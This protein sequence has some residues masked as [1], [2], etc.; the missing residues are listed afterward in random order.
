MSGTSTNRSCAVVGAGAAG[1]AAARRLQ[2]A[3]LA[4][5]LFDK[6]RQPGGRLASRRT[7]HGHFDHGLR[8]LAPQQ[9]HAESPPGAPLQP[10]PVD[11]W[12]I[13]DLRHRV[14]PSREVFV[15]VPS[16]NEIARH[17]ST[18]LNLRQ[19]RVESIKRSSGRWQVDLVDEASPQTFD[20]VV[21][22]V[23]QPQLQP[24][25]PDL[26]L[27]ADLDTIA[28]NPCWTLLWVPTSEMPL[29]LPSG[30]PMRHPSIDWLAREDSKP[31][32]V[33]PA[34]YVAH[35]T[36]PWSLEMLEQPADTVADMLKKDAA[37]LLGISAG[38]H[39]AVSHRWRFAHVRQALGR[40]Q[41]RLAAGLHYASDGCLGDGVEH[42]IASGCAAANALLRDED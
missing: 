14:T 33:G 41:R 22:T 24:L 38:A 39:F 9:I 8:Y 17:W 12:Q 16:N 18:G 29:S 19:Q 42:A 30:Y 37:D 6:G 36:A 13:A 21:V 32:R 5:T 25:L 11:A 3:G 15:G 4:V 7:A 2:A 34:R 10:A 28:Y 1:L 26:N 20:A 27:S 35:A 31:G 23:P 40:P